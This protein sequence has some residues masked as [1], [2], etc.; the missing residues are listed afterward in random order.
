MSAVA[1][2][3]FGGTPAVLL[4]SLLLLLGRLSAKLEKES[5]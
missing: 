1:S 4:V 5:P 2:S 3:Y